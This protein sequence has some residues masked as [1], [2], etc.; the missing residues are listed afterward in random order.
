MIQFEFALRAVD[1]RGQWLK[2][3]ETEG[4]ILRNGLR[5]QDGLTWDM[6]DPDLTTMTKLISKTKTSL[7]EPYKFDLTAV[8]EIRERLL[9][10]RPQNAVGPVLLA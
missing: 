2:T 6:V 1:V 8:P 9:A 5:W 4:G 7:P 3:N 10:I